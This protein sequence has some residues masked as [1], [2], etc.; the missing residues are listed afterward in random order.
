M[1]TSV[2]ILAD[3]HGRKD[4]GIKPD[5][6]FDLAIR[7][8]DLAQ[9]SK[10]SEFR[11]TLDL[12]HKIPAPVKV[13]IARNHEITLEEETYRKHLLAAGVKPTDSVAI[14][15]Y[16]EIGE[17]RRLL[18]AAAKEDGIIFLKEGTH[19]L[20][21]PNG[22][23]PNIYANPWTLRRKGEGSLGSSEAGWAYQ[24]DAPEKHAR[25]ESSR[26]ADVFVTHGPPE[27]LL[28]YVDRRR[29]GCPALFKAVCQGRPLLHCFGHIHSGWGAKLVT[30]RGAQPLSPTPSHMTEIDNEASFVLEKLGFLK[31]NRTDDDE[32]ELR[33]KHRLHKLLAQG[34]C[35]LDERPIQ[36]GKQTIFVNAAIQGDLDMPI[37]P[38]IALLLDLPRSEYRAKE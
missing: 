2:L 12:L 31:P 22:A 25:F 18:V 14:R 10:I 8:G 19:T 33:K 1:P 15:E 16:G 21:L 24:Y 37:Q 4:I 20:H 3:T 36:Q 34:Y 5:S 9:Q 35:Q 32:M 29:T 23:G 38:P 7:C 13:V 27:G 28:D 17:A 30:W 6:K 11:S 26:P